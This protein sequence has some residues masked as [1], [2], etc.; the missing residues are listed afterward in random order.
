VI[1]TWSL[2]ARVPKCEMLRAVGR[3]ARE[4]LILK[5]LSGITPYAYSRDIS[6]ALCKTNKWDKSGRWRGR[7]SYEYMR[8]SIELSLEERS[9]L[10]AV[11]SL[12]AAAFFLHSFFLPPFLLHYG[13]WPSA[14]GAVI[15][16]APRKDGRRRGLSGGQQ[17]DRRTGHS[18]RSARVRRRRGSASHDMT[19]AVGRL[20]ALVPLQQ[21]TEGCAVIMPGR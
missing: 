12:S 9:I 14:F 3:P 20:G 10:P 4:G 17:N 1:R 11:S 19:A 2:F 8:L 6:F 13:C 15:R 7:V 18:V 5:D 21:S 16:V